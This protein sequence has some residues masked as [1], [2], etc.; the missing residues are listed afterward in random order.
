MNVMR[1]R[2]AHRIVS[3]IPYDTAVKKSVY[4]IPKETYR[5][6]SNKKW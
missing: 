1:L 2:F 6:K 5:H 4:M 3:I